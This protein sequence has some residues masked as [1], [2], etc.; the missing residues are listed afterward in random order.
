[1]QNQERISFMTALA[2][3]LLYTLY[4]VYM[5]PEDKGKMSGWLNKG[6]EDL[7]ILIEVPPPT[8]E[9][10]SYCTITQHH[11]RGLG[12]VCFQAKRGENPDHITSFFNQRLRE[13]DRH[14]GEKPI[15]KFSLILPEPDLDLVE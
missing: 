14:Y 3:V 11:T 15:L 7:F 4:G 6:E 10:A 9:E 13:W 2:E 8:K 1:M 12:E 5:K